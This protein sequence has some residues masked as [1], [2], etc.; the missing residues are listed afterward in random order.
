MRMHF[1]MSYSG[2][3]NS[4]VTSVTAAPLAHARSSPPTPY[5]VHTL[6]STSTC[7]AVIVCVCSALNVT[8]VKISS[9]LGRAVAR[10]ARAQSPS[11]PNAVKLG[12]TP[13]RQSFGGLYSLPQTSDETCNHPRGPPR[14]GDPAPRLLFQE[15][16]FSVQQN[17]RC[18]HH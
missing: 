16:K 14:Y 2:H 7:I 8:G 1:W 13:R 5:G 11:W 12:T 17:E 3:C 18:L 15:R 10:S 6:P 4:W 9:M